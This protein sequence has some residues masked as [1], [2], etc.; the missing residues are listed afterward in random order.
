MARLPVPGQDSGTWGSL[1]NDFLN[2]SLN[3]DGSLKSGALTSAGAQMTS[4]KGQASGY[5]PL[6]ASSLVPIANIPT[7]TSSSTVAAGNDTRITGAVQSSVVTTKGDMLV[8]TGSGTIVRLGVGSS[9]QVLTVDGDQT[10]G[11]KW[12]GSATNGFIYAVDYGAE[13]DGNTDDASALQSAI[14]AAISAGKPLFLPSGTAIVGTALSIASP[15]TIVG[16]GR[17]AT[18]LKAKDSLNGYVISFTGGSAGVGIVGAHFSD[19]TIDGNCANQTAGGGIL[20]NGAV[21]C[22]FERLH[23][24]SCYNWGLQLGPITGGAFGHHNRV[25]QC[26]F[27]SNGVSSAGYGGGA[28]MTSSDENWFYGS[29]FEYLGGSTNPDGSGY[30][31]MLYDRAGLQYIVATNFVNGYNDCIG[32]RVQDTKDTKI[33]ACT[34]DGLAGD[35]VWISGTKCIISGNVFTCPGEAGSTAASGVHLEYNTSYNVVTGNSLETSNSSNKTRSLIREESTGG[36]NNNIIT[37]NALYQNAAPTVALL[38]SAGTSTIVRNNVGWTTE[39]NGTA[40]VANG[41]TS[42][43]VTHGLSVTPAAGNISVTA[44]NN[45]GNAAQFWV[46]NITSSAFTINVDVDPGA[47]TAT[48]AWLIRM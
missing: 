7:G 13:F 47:T 44:T 1:L 28:T 46:D 9:N 18:T 48:F 5:A 11:V 41:T 45:M 17:Q 24:T 39:S 42:I 3:T 21:Q 15:I 14:S 4:E 40:T 35:S 2:Q 16:S 31:V 25:V 34:F 8:A 32:V 23:I 30:P 22:S 19:F 33:E 36:S 6:N 20:A 38:E 12:S 37:N 29:D 27:D 26:L 10:A 43:A